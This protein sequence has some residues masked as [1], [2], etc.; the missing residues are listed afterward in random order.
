MR[1]L[2]FLIYLP[3]GI[4]PCNRSTI[5][6]VEIYFKSECRPHV[7]T[8]KESCLEKSPI[9]S[10]RSISGSIVLIFSSFGIL[11]SFTDRFRFR[12]SGLPLSANPAGELLGDRKLKQRLKYKINK[13]SGEHIRSGRMDKKQ[14]FDFF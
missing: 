9:R 10:A 13:G 14:I 8:G 12:M 2:G 6:C 7:V 11:K 3:T 4:F 1:F 5:V